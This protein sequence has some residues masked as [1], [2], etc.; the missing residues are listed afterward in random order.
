MM[1][2][3]NN[4]GIITVRT[5]LANTKVVIGNHVADVYSE[6]VNDWSQ[7]ITGTF[8]KENED[9]GKVLDLISGNLMLSF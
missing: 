5:Q 1:K 8:S 9:K 6:L 4:S 3:E 2:L 7:R